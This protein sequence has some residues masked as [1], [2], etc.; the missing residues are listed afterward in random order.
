MRLSAP[1]PSPDP[2]EPLRTVLT[3]ADTL[4]RS[5]A[6][7]LVRRV[8]ARF[9]RSSTH[10]AEPRASRQTSEAADPCDLAVLVYELLDANQDTA[11]LADNLPSDPS[12]LEHLD[13][14]R[15]LHRVGREALANAEPKR[16][17]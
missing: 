9:P 6:R 1:A 7:G 15:R 2:P 13:Y 8:A 16:S 17:T 10:T 4:V 3:A 11:R 12:W 14:L 5:S